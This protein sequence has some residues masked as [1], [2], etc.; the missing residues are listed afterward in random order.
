M[1]KKLTLEIIDAVLVRTISSIIWSADISVSN[2][3]NL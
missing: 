1:S 2:H 3:V